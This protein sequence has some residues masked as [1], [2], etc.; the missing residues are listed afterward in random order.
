MV[1]IAQRV[2]GARPWPAP[3]AASPYLL[4]AG[5][6]SS[7]GCAMARLGMARR[8][9]SRAAQEQRPSTGP[10]SESTRRK[11][12]LATFGTAIGIVTSFVTIALGAFDLREK[13]SPVEANDAGVSSSAYVEGV[14]EVCDEKEESQVARR[15]NAFELKRRMKKAVRFPRQ[16]VL[17]LAFVHRELD[18]GDY[19]LSTFAGLAPPEEVAPEHR[20]LVRRWEANID[21]LRVHRDGIEASTSRARLLTVLVRLNRSVAETESRRVEAGLRRLGG[22]AC[23][24]ER[25]QPVPQ[26]FLPRAVNH[27]PEVQS[28]P[29]TLTSS[30]AP[31]P[32]GTSPDLNVAAPDP[33]VVP[34]PSAAPRP[35]P[36]VVPPSTD[37]APDAGARPNVVVPRVGNQAP[38]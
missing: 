18:R 23:D 15:A 19:A 36:N 20:A 1:R 16:R 33:D 13:V 37:R 4:C 35:D 27:S 2:A 24:I 26:V 32:G 10:R 6:H 8:R 5:C 9:R 31:P 11:I 21:R 38:R 30:P 25:P 28:T 22:T 34:P 7:D 3:C 29:G 14:A 12:R 17:L